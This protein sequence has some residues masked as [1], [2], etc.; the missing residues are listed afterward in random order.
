MKNYKKHISKD[1]WILIM[2]RE[3]KHLTISCM[4]NT[5]LHINQK[6]NELYE[7]NYYN[8]PSE[9][10]KLQMRAYEYLTENLSTIIRQYRES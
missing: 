3:I 4:Y 7:K 5:M 1:K 2:S 10:D 6:K 9:E 8:E